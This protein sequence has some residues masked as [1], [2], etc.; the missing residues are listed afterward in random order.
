MWE[1]FSLDKFY[2]GKGFLLKKEPNFPALF[3]KRSGIK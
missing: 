3:K 2:M 1:D